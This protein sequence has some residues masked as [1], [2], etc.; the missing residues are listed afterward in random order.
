MSD[1]DLNNNE[2]LDWLTGAVGIAIAVV[3]WL[4]L[5]V[6][7]IRVIQKAGYSGWWILIGLVPIVNVVMFL[8]FAYSRWP[9][10][11]ENDEFRDRLGVTSTLR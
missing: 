1:I 3:V 6:A 5:V 8:V 2:F 4:I 9:I 7:Y 10:Q 11:R